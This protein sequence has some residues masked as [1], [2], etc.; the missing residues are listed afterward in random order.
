MPDPPPIR[1]D[2]F[3][4]NPPPIKAD[5]LG[6]APPPITPNSLTDYVPPGGLNPV[7]G[8]QAQATTSHPAGTLTHESTHAGDQGSALMSTTLN[9]L[10]NMKHEMLKAVAQNLRG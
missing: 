5:A 9:N 3:G 7:A 2:V 10:V 1:A 8:G 6:P 4:P